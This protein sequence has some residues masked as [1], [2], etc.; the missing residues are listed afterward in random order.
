MNQINTSIRWALVLPAR[1]WVLVWSWAHPS[2]GPALA[3]ALDTEARNAT[4]ARLPLRIAGLAITLPAFA[5]RQAAAERRSTTRTEGAALAPRLGASRLREAL[6][7]LTVAGWIAAF[8]LAVHS[9]VTTGT[10][11]PDYA[12]SPGEPEVI[13]VQFH[14]AA[15]A[16][17]LPTLVLGSALARRWWRRRAVR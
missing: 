14:L 4:L 12:S 5:R 3:E 11:A 9:D 15:L 6:V 17:G 10:F 7:W 16:A 13:S 8:A 1:A 2:A